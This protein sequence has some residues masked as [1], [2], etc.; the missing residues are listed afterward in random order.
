MLK[1]VKNKHTRGGPKITVFVVVVVV[2]GRGALLLSAPAWY[3]Y[4]T[5]LR[6][7]WPSGVLEE[8]CIGSV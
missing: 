1:N 7:S 4:V 5:A 8:R 6:I 2:E 3:V